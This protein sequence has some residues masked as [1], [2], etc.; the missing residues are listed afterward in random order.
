VRLDV[1][2]YIPCGR[3]PKTIVTVEVWF[4]ADFEKLE[5][6]TS[7]L[8]GWR[9]KSLQDRLC[10]Q[11]CCRDVARSKRHIPDYASTCG[12]NSISEATSKERD[13]GPAGKLETA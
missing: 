1:H 13:M 9:V 10:F 3:I 5:G 4:V 8:Y 12:D 2:L 7:L 11:V 6:D